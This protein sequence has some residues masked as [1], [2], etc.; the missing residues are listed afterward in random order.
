M[1]HNHNKNDKMS[2]LVM[3]IEIDLIKIGNEFV[4]INQLD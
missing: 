2:S 1:I 4:K 3:V